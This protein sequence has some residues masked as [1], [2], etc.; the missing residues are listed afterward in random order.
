MQ[1]LKTC[2]NEEP[3]KSPMALLQ[4]HKAYLHW[5][6]EPSCLKPLN[7]SHIVR[8]GITA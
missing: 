2:I 7:I 4:T 3:P 5:W 1:Y 6:Q 8:F